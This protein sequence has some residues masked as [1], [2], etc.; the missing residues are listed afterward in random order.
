MADQLI[1]NVS[2][3]DMAEFARLM[4]LD[5]AYYQSKYGDLPPR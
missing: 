2:K 4:A 3:E 5:V 1:E